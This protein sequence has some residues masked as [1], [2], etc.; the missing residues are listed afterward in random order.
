MKNLLIGVTCCVGLLASAVL[1]TAGTQYTHA[2]VQKPVIT[3]AMVEKPVMTKVV[4]QKTVM[5][6]H[7]MDNNHKMVVLA[8]RHHG[9]RHHVNVHRHHNHH[10]H[11]HG[12]IVVAPLLL[13]GVMDRS[14]VKSSHECSVYYHGK[15]RFGHYSRRTGYC[16][17]HVHG[18]KMHFSH[19]RFVNR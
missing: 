17:V 6:K 10:R 12:T 9:Y 16:S 13:N 18:Q 8:D 1:A 15:V 19:F 7:N 5:T 4:T 2:V 14:M 3:Q 11:H